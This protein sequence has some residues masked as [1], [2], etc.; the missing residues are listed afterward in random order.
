M[1][2]VL[3]LLT[4]LAVCG[5]LGASD[6]RAIPVPSL[7]VEALEKG[8]EVV[9]V[10]EIV[11]TREIERG[12]YKLRGGEVPAR[13]VEATLRASRVLKGASAEEYKVRYYD[14]EALL[15]YDGVHEGRYG[16]FFLKRVGEA[17]SFVSPYHI[18]L[19][20][21]RGT[22]E[23]RGAALARVATEMACVLKSEGAMKRPRVEAILA[24]A[25][26]KNRA[27]TAALQDAARTQPEPLNYLAADNLIARGDL[28][29]LPLAEHALLKSADIHVEEEGYRMS[30]GWNSI[31]DISDRRAIPTLTRLTRAPDART[32]QSALR[33]LANTKDAAAIQPVLE[34]LEDD[35]AGVRWYAVMSLAEL[36]GE[37]D[38]G[39][40]WYPDLKAFEADE[41]LYITHW[42]AWAMSRKGW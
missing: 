15:G 13:L 38:E 7:D 37:D 9:T 3:K 31:E 36:A 10:G 4:V 1:K 14:P 22:C 33:A 21:T 18:S 16:V 41:G 19:F 11:S 27:A 42:K 8:A 28:T 29:Q 34:G 6:A 25:T 35:D 24:L 12:T 40:K 5:L 32:R 20:A 23:S 39:G 17:Y 30:T 2:R 26:I